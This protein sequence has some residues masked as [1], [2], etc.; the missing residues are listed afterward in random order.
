M[1]EKLTLN[2]KE[3]NRLIILNQ[4]EAKQLGADQA[5]LL[6]KISERQIWRLL[7]T[8]RKEGAEGLAHGNRDRKPANALPIELT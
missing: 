3:Q 6:L 5:A 2:R 7:A 1:K 8:Y 4:L